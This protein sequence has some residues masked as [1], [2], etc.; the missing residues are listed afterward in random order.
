MLLMVEKG[1]RGEICQATYQYV[2]LIQKYMKDHDKRKESPFLKYWDVYSLY[3]WTMS[4]NL[5]LSNFK[6]VGEKS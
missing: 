5:P 2:K 3:G 4:R 6:W 1:I